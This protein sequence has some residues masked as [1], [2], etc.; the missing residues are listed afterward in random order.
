MLM[1]PLGCDSTASGLEMG[2]KLG[3]EAYLERAQ[4]CREMAERV[5]LI[6]TRNELLEMALRYEALAKHA[7]A[8]DKD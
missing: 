5:S 3:K 7:E 8:S 1:S 2:E 4:L 6:T